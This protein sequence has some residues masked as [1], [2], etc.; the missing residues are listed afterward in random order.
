MSDVKTVRARVA[1]PGGF[2]IEI[3]AP[4]ETM[5]FVFAGA[6]AVQECIAAG[7]ERAIK[8]QEELDRLNRRIVL[9]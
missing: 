5:A 2:G 9:A 1:T 4:V 8:A 3:D 7:M 6:G